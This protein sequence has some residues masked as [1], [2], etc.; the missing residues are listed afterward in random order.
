MKKFTIFLLTFLLFVGFNYAKA[1]TRAATH[2]KPAYG[3]GV[4]CAPDDGNPNKVEVDFQVVT[5]VEKIINPMILMCPND[6]LLAYAVDGELFYVDGD[7]NEVPY[8]PYE[9]WDTIRPGDGEFHGNL[10][11]IQFYYEGNI[12]E[13]T[14]FTAFAT[15]VLSSGD[16][17]LLQSKQPQHVKITIIDKPEIALLDRPFG[18][19]CEGGEVF[20]EA[21]VTKWENPDDETIEIRYSWMHN[22]VWNNPFI[23]FNPPDEPPV[24]TTFDDLEA[25]INTFGFGVKVWAYVPHPETGEPTPIEAESCFVTETFEFKVYPQPT[26]DLRETPDSFCQTEEDITLYYKS[27]DTYDCDVEVT[28]ESYLWIFDDE[29]EHI[30]IPLGSKGPFVLEAPTPPSHGHGHHGHGH[31]GHGHHPSHPDNVFKTTV[32][33]ETFAPDATFMPAGEYEIHTTIE[34][35]NLDEWCEY[36]D[37]TN[38]TETMCLTEHIFTLIIDSLIVAN[39]GSDAIVCAEREI[40][41]NGNDPDYDGAVGTWTLIDDGGYDVTIDDVN[42]PNTLVTFEG[43][44]DTFEFEFVWTIVNGACET[45]DTVVVTVRELPYIFFETTA[46]CALTDYSIQSCLYY[47]SGDNEGEPY[48]YTWEPIDIFPLNEED[49]TGTTD[50]QCFYLPINTETPGSGTMII[51]VIDNFGCMVTDTAEINIWEL[52]TAILEDWYGVC[53]EEELIIEPAVTGGHPDY[54]QTWSSEMIEGIFTD[55][56]GFLND[57]NLHD[58]TYL[59]VITSESGQGYITVVVMDSYGCT[60]TATARVSIINPAIEATIADLP[61]PMCNNTLVTLH[62]TIHEVVDP[63]ATEQSYEWWMYTYDLGCDGNVFDQIF[64]GITDLDGTYKIEVDDDIIQ[65]VKFVLVVHHEG[66]S[67][68]CDQM[69]E[70]NCI[71]I[72]PTIKIETGGPDTVCHGGSVELAFALSNI[73]IQPQLDDPETRIYYRIYEND[74]YF[75]DIYDI[76]TLGLGLDMIKFTTHPSLHTS[77]EG[78]ESYC[79]RV[80][81]WQGGTQTTDPSGVPNPWEPVCHVFSECH[82]VTVLKDPVVYISGPVTIAK[83]PTEYPQFVANVVGGVGEPAFVWYLDGVEQEETSNIYTLENLDILG[84]IGQHNIAVKVKQLNYSGCETELFIHYF[85]IVC[86]PATVEIVG[87]EAAC[88]GDIVTLTAQVYTDAQEYTIQWKKDGNYLPGETGQSYEFIVTEPIDVSDYMVEVHL[89]GCEIT[90]SPVFYFQAM[91]RPVAVVEDYIICEYG[92]VEVTV[93]PIIWDGQIYRYLWFDSEGADEPFDITY[94][95]H[96][97]FTYG[98]MQDIVSTFYVQMEMLNA[99]CTSDRF[100]F[101]ITQQGGLEIVPII[102]STLITCVNTPV[103]FKLGDDP[104][105]DPNKPWVIRNVEWWVDGFEQWG[106]ELDSII[107]SFTTAGEHNVYAKITYSDN[108]CIFVTDIITIEVREIISVDIAGPHEYCAP[109]TELAV[110]SAIVYPIGTTN[111]YNYQWYLNG[112]P[113]TGATSSTYTVNEDPSPQPYVYTVIVTDPASG[114]SMPGGPFDITIYQLPPMGVTISETEICEG[115]VITLTADPGENNMEYKWYE[116]TTEIG[117]TPILDIT[118]TAGTHTYYYKATQVGSACIATSNNVTV[119]VHAIPEAPVIKVDDDKICSGNPITLEGNLEGIYQWYEQG[120]TNTSVIGGKIISRQPTANNVITDYFYY[121]TVTQY[122]SATF[123]GCTSL[124]SNTV[125]V[126]VHPEIQVE[127]LGATEVCEWAVGEQHLALTAVVTTLTGQV[128]LQPGVSYHYKWSYRQGN[129]PYEVFY[130]DDDNYYAVAPNNLQ[131]N[132]PAAPYF[133]IVEVTAN[134]YDCTAVDEHGPV[135]IL[136][137]PTVDLSVNSPAVC[138]GGM[139]TVTADPYPPALPGN[140]YYYIWT[141]NGN[142]LPNHDKEITVELAWPLGP[143]EIA[144]TVEL[145]YTSLSCFGSNSINVNVTSAPSLATTQDI[146][147][148]PLAGMC[149]GGK[150]FMYSEIVDFD[151]A[152]IVP[153]FT[154]EWEMDNAPYPGNGADNTAVLNNPGTYIFKVQALHT[155]SSLGCNTEWALFDPVTVV[156]QATVSIY[157]KDDIYDYCVG[158]NNEIIPIL[159]ITDPTIQLGDIYQWSSGGWFSDEFSFINQIDPL[160]VEFNVISEPIYTLKVKFDNPTCKEVSSSV[161]LKVVSDPEWDIVT[162]IP[163]SYDGLCVGETVYVHATVKEDLPSGIITWMYKFND[164]EFFAWDGPGYE[165]IHKPAQEGEYIYRATYAHKNPRSGCNLDDF[166]KPVLVVDPTITPTATFVTNGETPST[167]AN[168]PNGDPVVLTVALT[169]T[170]PFHFHVI[171]NPGYDRYHTSYGYTYSFTVTPAVTTTYII[172][173]L[174]DNT[175]CVTGNFINSDITVVV[176]NVTILNPYLEVCG[177][178]AEFHLKMI[179]YVNSYAVVTFPCGVP[180]TVPIVKTG[181]Y[182]TISVPIPSCVLVGT[183]DIIIS[184]DGCDYNATI[185]KNFDGTGDGNSQLIYRRWEGNAE[186]LAVSNNYMNPSNPYY[187]GGFEFIAYQWYKNGELIPGATQQYY[188]DPNGVS[189]D[190]S[191]RLR[192]YRVDQNGNRI[193]D[194]IEFFTCAQTFNPTLSL[195]VYPVPAQVNEPVFVELDLTPAEMEGAILDVYDAKGAHIQQ[196][197]VVSTITEITGFKAQGAYYGKITTGTNEIKAVKFVIVK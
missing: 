138:Q 114:C 23:S 142:V 165:K 47:N 195:K 158:A 18:V 88:L 105:L 94:V 7:G 91:P 127:I 118:P 39:A 181:D 19:L 6:S 183:H 69:V 112:A 22:E 38:I 29:G 46:T 12:S 135:N 168:D 103:L 74:L 3:A 98:E 120:L 134:E 125:V 149:V 162:M 192:G 123:T 86:P 186:V 49:L 187:N 161:Q 24:N 52:P 136:A 143:N 148:L 197:K 164:E 60:D 40:I 96:R 126:S 25:G 62:A 70:S 124:P 171:G 71:D 33:P 10:S 68:A 133:F 36:P 194:M 59:N 185:V 193:G 1:Q 55:V 15:E 102:P 100:A 5:L 196:V 117:T 188:Q 145:P 99:V 35:K 111:Q 80:E 11:N 131:V 101:T 79:Y 147:G 8:F 190:Y 57:G 95:N 85:D 63:Y 4:Y 153:T 9:K 84:T 48:A 76:Y 87:P 144:V 189:G 129:N 28:W 67:T 174:D 178:T 110:L 106:D 152:L 130:E 159:N 176:T 14:W 172:E 184:I 21:T 151:A 53:L 81:V 119:V 160:L 2:I 77:E 75:D 170:P 182:S 66:Y 78:P 82:W 139:V 27:D 56:D 30:E 45:T 20:L 17:V 43:V 163:N 132:D 31:H 128:G 41:M 155:N 97:L 140:P 32:T 122:V 93:E 92:A 54:S 16:E 175:R 113:I 42:D 37:T 104:N 65:S 169:G 137:K 180:V 141:V 167:C 108:D 157:P 191:V 154:Y 166:D 72:I 51:T 61:N 83:L 109:A 73:K 58:Q 146:E 150:L 34:V 121:A 177:G 64:T 116:G 13:T 156:P 44:D 26:I 115:G 90:L 107:Y 173:S 50:E 89:C 179:D